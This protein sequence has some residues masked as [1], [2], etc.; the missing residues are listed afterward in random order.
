VKEEETRRVRDRAALYLPRL[1]SLLHW[2]A[3]RSRGC[4]PF[5][6]FTNTKGLGRSQDLHMSRTKRVNGIEFSFGTWFSLFVA[7][8]GSMVLP[9]LVV[10]AGH[11]LVVN[12][13]P[14][15]LPLLLHFSLAKC[16]F[17][18]RPMM[19]MM[20]MR[21]VQALNLQKNQREF[22]LEVFSFLAFIFVRVNR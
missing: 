15:A 8:V 2:T 22:L 1:L 3:G 20:E 10:G 17:V 5:V 6:L 14:F 21:E 18:R 16:T 11:F 12:S 4:L 7:L 19:L 13:P 9:Y